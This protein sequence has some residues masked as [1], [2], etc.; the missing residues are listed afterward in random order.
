MGGE[1]HIFANSFLTRATQAK[2]LQE[3]RLPQ[4][5]GVF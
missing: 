2:D 3:K 4:E 5:N 1:Y